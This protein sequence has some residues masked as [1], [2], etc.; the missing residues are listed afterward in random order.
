MGLPT[1][2]LAQAAGLRAVLPVVRLCASI[3]VSQWDFLRLH[4]RLIDHPQ[5]L[6]L[7]IAG[8]LDGEPEA[9][10]NL[11]LSVWLSPC[12]GEQAGW[13]A[14]GSQRALCSSVGW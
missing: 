7:G 6:A 2:L 9:R 5:E 1:F 14:G 10:E 4:F 13:L 8:V 12:N 11:L 3:A